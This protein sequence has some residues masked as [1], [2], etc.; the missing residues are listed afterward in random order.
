MGAALLELEQVLRSQKEYLTAPEAQLLQVCKSSAIRAF[1]FGAF[2]GGSTAWAVTWRLSRVLRVNISGGA[3]AFL[4]FWRFGHSLESCVDHILSKDGSRLQRELANLM[5]K[6]HSHIPWAKQLLCKRFYME[7]VY[8]DT[9]SG[10]AMLRWRHR[11]YSGDSEQ[12]TGNSDHHK[13]SEDRNANDQDHHNH[14]LKETDTIKKVDNSKPKQVTVTPTTVSSFDQHRLFCIF[15]F[16]GAPNKLFTSFQMNLESQQA[17]IAED[18][19]SSIFGG[20]APP[21]EEIH[22][23]ATPPG[24]GPRATHRSHRQSHR[25]NRRRMRLHRESTL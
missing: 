14:S 4:G 7:T 16:Y 3:A 17:H 24:S 9:G 21:V 19:I 18:P 12:K 25:R 10:E 11:N 23:P 1:T 22:H 8:N 5:V 13:D 20:V 2:L 15:G 6:N